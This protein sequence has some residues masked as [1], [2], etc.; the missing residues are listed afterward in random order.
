M[1]QLRQAVE[2]SRDR[3][4]HLEAALEH[5]RDIGTAMGILMT[6]HKVTREAAFEM[7]RAASQNQNRKVSAL[8]LD[9]IERGC[10]PV[11]APE[12]KG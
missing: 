8:A 3:V 1:D 4:H 12:S 6:M 10:L 5:S 9:V 7:L 2:R 11:A